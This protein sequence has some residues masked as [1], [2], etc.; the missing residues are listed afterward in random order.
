MVCTAAMR[1]LTILRLWFGRS[2]F[3]LFLVLIALTLG[4][5]SIVGTFDF[6]T[7]RLKCLSVN[8]LCPTREVIRCCLF[9]GWVKD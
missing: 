8:S 6:T 2:S 4:R 3:V 1:A 5:I 7:F 9:V